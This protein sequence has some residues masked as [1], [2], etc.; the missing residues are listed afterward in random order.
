MINLEAVRSALLSSDPY[1]QMDQLVRAELAAGRKTGEIVDDFRPLIQSTLDIPTLTEDGK[2]A[3]LST[4]DALTGNCRVD[5]C[6]QDPPNHNL[7]TEEEI[8]QLPRWARVAFAARS[9]RRVLPLF[10]HSWPKSQKDYIS[11]VFRA[12]EFA[13]QSATA[14]TVDSRIARD[15]A[16]DA[17]V[18]AVSAQ[19]TP[20]ANAVARAAARAADVAA[21][22]DPVAYSYSDGGR[23]SEA[24]TAASEAIGSTAEN[25]FRHDFDH[26]ASLSKWNH[27]TDD[28][29]VPP[30]V[31]GPLW[32]EGP[33][34]DW[35]TITD[36]PQHKK[37]SLTFYSRERAVGQ[38]TEDDVVNLFNALNRYHI[39]R[40]GVPL[41]Y[42][43]LRSLLP[44]LVPAEV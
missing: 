11:L 4:L 32:P 24:V 42:E 12:V 33:P 35:P 40:G 36:I 25:P 38:I 20:K 44:A 13:E 10:R 9:A 23:A 14:A 3:F 37:L 27:W 18:A 43:D 15:I 34:K 7:P 41:T 6:Y 31:F 19:A 28:T 1:E 21:D 22:A 5:Q 30:E 17:V 8:T 26:L 29:P 39:A 2:E 16:K